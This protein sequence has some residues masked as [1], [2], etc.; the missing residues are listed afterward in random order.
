MRLEATPV[1]RE[2]SI[3]TIERLD[4]PPS[5][6]DDEEGFWGR[7]VLERAAHGE[8]EQ[9]TLMRLLDWWNPYEKRSGE[10]KNRREL[11]DHVTYEAGDLHRFA[12][13][14][15]ELVAGHGHG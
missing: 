15:R 9:A 7:I 8:L 12:R 10:Y 5:V 14:V 6:P 4:P 13:E 1:S 2:G 3:L 11:E